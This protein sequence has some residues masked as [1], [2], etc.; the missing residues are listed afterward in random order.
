MIILSDEIN[1]GLKLFPKHPLL[2]TL[3]GHI[4]SR[5]GEKDKT[6]TILDELIVRS[7]KEY[8]SPFLIAS[9]YTDLGDIDKANECLEM[10]YEK[11]DIYIAHFKFIYLNDPRFNNFFR[12]IG[13]LD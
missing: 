2:L 3:V 6:F 4:Y 13:L 11:R 7:K 8:I 10:C 9:L 12:K 5:I 1:K